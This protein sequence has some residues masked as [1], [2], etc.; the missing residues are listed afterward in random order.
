MNH[1]N[2]GVNKTIFVCVKPNLDL[3]VLTFIT[4]TKYTYRNTSFFSFIA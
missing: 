2:A 3:S 4:M 1:K